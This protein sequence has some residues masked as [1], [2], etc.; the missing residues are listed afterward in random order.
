MAIGLSAD[1]ERR[2]DSVAGVEARAAHLG[3][4]PVGA[5]VAR[6]H[7]LVGLEAAGGEDDGAARNRAF[8]FRSKRAH[9]GDGVVVV[10][11]EPRG[12]GLVRD[13]DVT[14]FGDSEQAV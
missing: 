1:L 2:A 7:L 10:S 13:V 9:A 5:Q 3:Q 12:L 11:L 6:T 4:L 8:P 14:V